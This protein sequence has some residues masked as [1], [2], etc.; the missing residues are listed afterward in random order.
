MSKIKRNPDGTWQMIKLKP[1]PSTLWERI[2]AM[3]A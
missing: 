1:K 3:I 2:C